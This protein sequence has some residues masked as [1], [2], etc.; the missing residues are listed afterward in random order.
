M[1]VVLIQVIN[2]IKYLKIIFTDM[3]LQEKSST[4]SSIANLYIHN[5]YFFKLNNDFGI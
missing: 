1:F 2:A 3:M 4:S 5:Q